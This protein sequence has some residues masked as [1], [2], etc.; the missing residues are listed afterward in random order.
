M[1]PPFFVTWRIFILYF[2]GPIECLLS[3]KCF[4]KFDFPFPVL[5]YSMQSCGYRRLCFITFL[6]SL[7]GILT[8][9]VLGPGVLCIITN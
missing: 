8:L 7:V 9:P 1:C 3:S 6:Q 5:N 4:A 2:V